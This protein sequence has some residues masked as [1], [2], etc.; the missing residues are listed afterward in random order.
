M[1]IMKSR[2]AHLSRAFTLVELLVVIAII[3]I[4]AALIFP[5]LSAARRKALAFNCASNLKQDGLAIM[6]YTGDS[7]DVLPGPCEW[8]QRCYYFNT[9]AVNGRF[10]SEMAFYLSTYLGGKSPLK[11]SDTE[12]NYLKTM[13]CPGFGPFIPQAPTARMTGITY[14]TSF[15]FTNGAVSL[16]INPFGYPGIGPAEAFGTTPVKLSSL[17]KYGPITDIFALSDVDAEIYDDWPL[18]PD[19]PSHGDIRN[20]LYFDGHVKAYRGTQ[21]VASY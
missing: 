18:E 10:N 14:I 21:Y 2:V 19:A 16:A 13:Y 1:V 6:T 20:A 5:A 11:M 7:G 8:G 17:S 4:L 15:P 9:T 3:G 12:S